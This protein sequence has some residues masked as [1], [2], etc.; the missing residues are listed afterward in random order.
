MARRAVAVLPP[1]A[2]ARMVRAWGALRP[3][4]PDGFPAFAES[5]AWPGAFVAAC[6][7]GIT[8]AAVHAND[9]AGAIAA[10]T[11]LPP[12]FHPERFDVRP[13]A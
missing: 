7:S 2:R 10:G 8:L 4:T 5:R 11:A 3:M 6:H 12:P 1:L 9:L 13:A